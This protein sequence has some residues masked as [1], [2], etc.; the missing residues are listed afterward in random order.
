MLPQ[1]LS[2]QKVADAIFPLDTPRKTKPKPCK[3]HPSYSINP[4][5]SPVSCLSACSFPNAEFQFDACEAVSTADC[6]IAPSLV[7]EMNI[8][9]FNVVSERS[10]HPIATKPVRKEPNKHA[11]LATKL[12]SKQGNARNPSPGLHRIKIRSHSPRLAKRVPRKGLTESYVMVKTSTNPQK[13][14]MESM[15]EM[16]VENNLLSSKDLEELLA[17]YLTLNSKEYHD[18]IV[19]VFEQ[20]WLALT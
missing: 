2:P 14:F 7:N 10:L 17:C 1:C 9:V 12:S 20:I 4:L 11:L 19:K 16:I 8:D 18:M 3:Q 13:D 6:P 5:Q 15:V